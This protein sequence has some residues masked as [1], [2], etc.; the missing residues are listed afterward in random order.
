[1]QNE[2]AQN[3]FY[4]EYYTRAGDNRNDIRGNPG[5][6]FQTLASERS[7]VCALREISH[8]SATAKVLDVGCGSGGGL[9]QFL[10]VGYHPENITAIDVQCDRLEAGKRIY[11]SISFLN[12]DA[13]AMGFPGASFDLVYE[14]TMFATLADDAVCSQIASEMLRVCRT[15]G[16]ILLVDWRTP[17]PWGKSYKALTKN[18]VKRLFR[19]GAH[20]ELVCTCPGAMVPPV[21][22]FISAYFPSMYFFVSAL[23]PLLVGQVAYLLRKK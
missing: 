15:G 12:S 6:L 22:R 1:M 19:I 20:S 23:F 11:P 21:G 17:N 10:R 3:K 18:R 13:S 4:R 2:Q 14:S 9:F 8:D 5:V 7:V 16:Y